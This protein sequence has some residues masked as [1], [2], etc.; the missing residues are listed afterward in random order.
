MAR[1]DFQSLTDS[2]CRP[3]FVTKASCSR[4]SSSTTASIRLCWFRGDSPDHNLGQSLHRRFLFL[5]FDITGYFGAPPPARG[6]NCDKSLVLAFFF[7]TNPVPLALPGRLF[8]AH[9]NRTTRKRDDELEGLCSP[10]HWCSASADWLRP[11][12]SCGT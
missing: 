1:F 3:G 2:N 7:C 4:F 12:H 10:C 11:F 5:L 8:C 9:A 6:R